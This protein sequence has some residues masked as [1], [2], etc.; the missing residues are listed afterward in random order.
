MYEGQIE[1][2]SPTP[3]TFHLV[4]VMSILQGRD[5]KILDARSIIIIII[6]IIITTFFFSWRDSPLVGFGLLL[7]DEEFCGF[8]ITH[9]DTPQ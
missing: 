4:K 5:A 9:N 8:L 2:I 3:K 1:F 6:I 7:I